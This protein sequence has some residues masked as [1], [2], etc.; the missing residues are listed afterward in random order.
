[1]KLKILVLFL[2]LF[3]LASSVASAYPNFK[4]EIL[5][6]LTDNAEEMG[7]TV[8]VAVR[9]ENQGTTGCQRVECGIYNKQV[10]NQ[11]GINTYESFAI[12]DP[13][14]DADNIPNC[15][16]TET[17]VD[18][19]NLCLDTAEKSKI[20]TF[21]PKAPLTDPNDVYFIFC[22]TFNHCYWEGPSSFERTDYKLDI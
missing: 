10:L 1:M 15:V 11:W 17:N 7:D 8:Q 18:S 12:F 19:I 3:I 13:F 6:T 20:I 2:T 16:T 4:L 22:G 21:L 14:L 9:V 5:S